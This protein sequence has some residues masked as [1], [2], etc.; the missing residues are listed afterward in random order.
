MARNGPA[1]GC[2]TVG[3]RG[4]PVPH[5]KTDM[6]ITH[7]C[8]E[9]DRNGNPQ[10][11]YLLTDD[12]GAILASWDEGYLGHHAVP[13]PWREQAYYALRTNISVDSY[14]WI[15]A[16]TRHPTWAHQVP[17]FSHLREWARV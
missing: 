2:Y 4:T 16:N 11:L 7:A 15:L 12:S 9:N 8:A 13:G 17:G 6:T 10:R 1:Q 14:H 5:R 3:T